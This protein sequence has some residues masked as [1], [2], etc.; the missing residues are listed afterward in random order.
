MQ[1]TGILQ[2]GIDDERAPGA[3]GANYCRG[4]MALVVEPSEL[5]SPCSAWLLIGQSLNFSSIR[6][7]R[8]RPRCSVK[9]LRLFQHFTRFYNVQ[10]LNVVRQLFRPVEQGRGRDL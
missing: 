4:L 1:H 6:A 5:S 8:L 2:Y 10:V 3:R 9:A 7:R